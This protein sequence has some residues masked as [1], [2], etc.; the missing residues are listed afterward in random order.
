MNREVVL[1]LGTT[2]IYPEYSLSLRHFRLPWITI[3]IDLAPSTVAML[4]LV[5]L[6]QP[7]TGVT[8]SIPIGIR[9]VHQNIN[10]NRYNMPHD[11]RSIINLASIHAATVG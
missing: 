9:I 4:V 3:I 8:R 6:I 7:V 11:F 10:H 5:I 1:K 2:R